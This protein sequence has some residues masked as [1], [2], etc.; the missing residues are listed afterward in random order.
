[1]AAAEGFRPTPTNPERPYFL[2]TGTLEPRKNISALLEAWREVRREHAVDLV[3]AG[4][5]R[6][7]FPR[8]APEPG[9]RMTGEATDA[10][11]ADL[12]SGAIAFVYPSWY[13][14]FGLPVLEAMQCGACV[15]TSNDASLREV[16]GEAAFHVPAADGSALAAT[17]RMVLETPELREMMRARAIKRAALFSWERTARLTREVYVEALRRFHA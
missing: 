10:Q 1:L 8:L 16:S 12:Y 5:V 7:D 13:E 11:L 14:G 3:L 9:L 2:F 17:M 6:A 15:I 4:R